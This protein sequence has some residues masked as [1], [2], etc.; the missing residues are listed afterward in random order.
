MAMEYS[1]IKM[2]IDTMENGKTIKKEDIAMR[3]L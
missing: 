2:D 3:S 1:E